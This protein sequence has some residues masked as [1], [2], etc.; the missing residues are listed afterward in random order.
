[1]GY[2]LKICSITTGGLIM[3][4]HVLEDNISKIEIIYGKM[5]KCV[6]TYN[7]YHAFIQSTLYTGAQ[8]KVNVKA[9][10]LV[11]LLNESETQT[12]NY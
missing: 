4:K 5:C 8:H 12:G 7:C 1:M 10:M 6:S 11:T 3:S 2:K 9:I